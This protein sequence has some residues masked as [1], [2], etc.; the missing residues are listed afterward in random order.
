MCLQ[1][2]GAA[3]MEEF[4]I[5]TFGSSFV[6]VSSETLV[7]F[8]VVSREMSTQRRVSTIVHRV[9]RELIE[10]SLVNFMATLR[11]WRDVTQACGKRVA[12]QFM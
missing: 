5:G 8:F 2:D 10:R 3:H 7:Q 1:G 11:E 9:R 6:R 4:P 12:L